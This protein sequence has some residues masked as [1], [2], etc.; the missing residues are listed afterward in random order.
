M[1]VIMRL[2]Q[3]KALAEKESK[4]SEC[5][6]FLCAGFIFGERDL[7]QGIEPKVDPNGYHTCDFYDGTVIARC[8]NGK[9]RMNL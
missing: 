1:E 9:W 8:T 5:T 4:D 6:V 2:A 3:A 7:E